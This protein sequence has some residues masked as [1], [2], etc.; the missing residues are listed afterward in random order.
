MRYMTQ[1]ETSGAEKWLVDLPATSR[2]TRPAFAVSALA[3]LGFAA[4]APFSGRPLAELNAF[5]PSMDAIVFVTDLVTAVLLFAQFRISGS[6]ALLALANGYLFTAVIVIPHALT[7]TGAFSPNGLLGAG[8]QTGSWLFIFWHLGFSVALLAYAIF[9]WEQLATR[10]A[11]A[12]RRP[13]I[14]LSIASAIVLVLFLT[15]LSTAGVEL[16][17]TIVDG[18]RISAFVV[19]P[20]SLTIFVTASALVLLW[21]SRR[22]VLDY[23]LMVVALVFILELI[24]SGLLPSVRFSLGFYAGRFLSLVTSSI[25]LI[26][27][28]EETTRLYLGLAK[29]NALLQREQAN[30]LMNLEAVAASMSHEIRQPIAVIAANV[31][32][33]IEF[34]KRQPPDLTNA[35]AALADVETTSQRANQVLQDIR[36]LFGK[37]STVQDRIDV[38]DAALSVL[39]ALRGA[40]RNHNIATRVELAS[41]L[42]NVF[43]H[44]G[45]LQEVIINLMQNAIEAMTAIEGNRILTV[46][47]GR[48]GSKSVFLEIEDTG[49]GLDTKNTGKV[50]EAFVTTKPNGMGL[51]LAI[52][53][54]IIDRHGGQLSAS[55]VHPYGANFRIV[56]PRAA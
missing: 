27:L 41:E 38:N 14:Y 54:L 29:S 3:L 47:T 25:V 17:P 10:V 37:A 33:A 21:V 22:S 44:R 49:P 16:L 35:L 13:A 24:F 19:Y 32:A 56:L 36:D 48:D 4:A 50:F 15:W 28:L 7:F 23:W 55:P 39:Q 12:S 40:L 20:I 5:F 43:G 11:A 8:P 1:P 31:G 2:Q 9:R 34:I 30:K 42:P 45:H 52:C 53:R 26:I 51:G 46:R 6:R 18:S